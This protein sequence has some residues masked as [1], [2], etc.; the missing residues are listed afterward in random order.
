MDV[1]ANL[2]VPAWI[3]ALLDPAMAAEGLALL[4]DAVGTEVVKDIVEHTPRRTGFLAG[5]WSHTMD[6]MDVVIRNP[7]EY[8]AYVEEDTKAHEIAASAAL[9]LRWYGATTVSGVGIEGTQQFAKKVQHPGTTGQRM[10]QGALDRLQ[11]HCDTASAA[12]MR[13]YGLA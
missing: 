13:H 7:T 11:E 1:T 5:E 3:E 6:G 2:D 12:L 4:M 9:I 10:V 8:A